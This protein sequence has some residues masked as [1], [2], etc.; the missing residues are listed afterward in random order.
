MSGILCPIRG[1]PGSQPAI[2][3]GISLAVETHEPLHFLFVVNL[4][5]LMATERGRTHVLSEEMRGMGEFI[6]LTAQAKAEKGGVNAGGTVRQGNV[7]EEII[8]MAKEM[9]ASYIIL[10]RPR[11][12]EGDVFTADRLETFIE[13]CERE[14]GSK[15]VLTNPVGEP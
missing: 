13:V 1:G 11:Q 2:E 15:V 5:F 7:M 3:L 12:E 4:D 6:L 14:T 8:A 9:E 10:G